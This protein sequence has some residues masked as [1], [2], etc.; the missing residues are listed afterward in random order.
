[1]VEKPRLIS[2][3]L[4]RWV[5]NAIMLYVMARTRPDLGSNRFGLVEDL[6]LLYLQRLHQL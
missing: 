3:Y 5:Y 6:Y 2:K 4:T 1:M